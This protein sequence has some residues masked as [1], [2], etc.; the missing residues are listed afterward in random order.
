MTP[1]P[2]IPQSRPPRHPGPHTPGE[3]SQPAGVDRHRQR[4]NGSDRPHFGRGIYGQPRGKNSARPP[5]ADQGHGLMSTALT[6]MTSPS[7]HPAKIVGMLRF[8]LGVQRRYRAD[9]ST[10]DTRTPITPF[11]WARPHLRN[12]QPDQGSQ[13]NTRTNLQIH[14]SQTGVTATQHRTS[15]SE[16]QPTP[17]LSNKEQTRPAP[18]LD[19]IS[20]HNLGCVE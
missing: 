4:L 19:A 13:P 15:R 5:R 10:M 16:P 17:Q 14:Q 3:A 12:H 20:W 9:V 1:R 7:V 6:S 2:L 18:L 8:L 11:P